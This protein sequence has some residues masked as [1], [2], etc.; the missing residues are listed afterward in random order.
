LEV[1]TFPRGI[2]L[3]TQAIDTSVSIKDKNRRF[4]KIDDGIGQFGLFARKATATVSTNRQNR[5][6]CRVFSCLIWT[7]VGSP[8]NARGGGV[9]KA[10]RH[11]G[12]E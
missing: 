6:L 9:P 12:A 10:P 4:L 2:Q 7:P 1:T 8:S 5:E 11:E 3:P